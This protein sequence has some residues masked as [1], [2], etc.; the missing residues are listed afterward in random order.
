MKKAHPQLSHVEVLKRLAFANK[1]ITLARRIYDKKTLLS[2]LL[3]LTLSLPFFPSY[4]FLGDGGAGW[5]QVP[6]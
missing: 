4:G 6:Y 3:C 5:A 2:I 1:N